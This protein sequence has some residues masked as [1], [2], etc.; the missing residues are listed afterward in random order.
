MAVTQEEVQQYPVR[1]KVLEK[2]ETLLGTGKPLVGVYP[3]HRTH[4]DGYPSATFQPSDVGSDYQT[5]VQNMRR[6]VF[7]VVIHQEAEVVGAEK[8]LDI[9][10]DA[11]H[12]VMNAFDNDFTLGGA[13]VDTKAVPSVWGAY[14]EGSGLTFYCEVKLEMLSVYDLS[15]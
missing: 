9:L 7:R 3:V 14:N 4:F 15:M 13:V 5:N 6:Y 8:A 11:M 10:W 2:L 1:Q 12:Q